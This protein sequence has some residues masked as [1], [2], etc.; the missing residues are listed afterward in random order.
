MSLKCF[1]GVRPLCLLLVQVAGGTWEGSN[2][3][4]RWFVPQRR[5]PERIANLD[6]TKRGIL[7]CYSFM[8]S[9]GPQ[10]TRPHV[11]RAG[12][13]LE[14]RLGHAHQREQTG[15]LLK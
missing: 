9:R 6:R 2:I 4:V 10:H 7:R 1:L 5:R 14:L 8:T 15:K 13:N 11:E 12:I 3:S